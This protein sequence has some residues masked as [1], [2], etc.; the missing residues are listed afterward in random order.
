LILIFR[1]FIEKMEKRIIQTSI[2]T[3]NNLQATLITTSV[4]LADAVL[5]PMS[6]TLLQQLSR[7]LSQAQEQL[8]ALQQAMQGDVVHLDR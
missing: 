4:G 8:T 6:E 1:K 7:M 2:G 5:A 3:L